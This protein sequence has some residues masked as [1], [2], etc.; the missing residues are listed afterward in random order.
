LGVESTLYAQPKLLYHL[1]DEIRPS[2]CEEKVGIVEYLLELVHN[3][4]TWGINV[5]CMAVIGNDLH[6]KHKLMLSFPILAEAINIFIVVIM[7]K[8]CVI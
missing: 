5:K 3:T 1:C 6:V 4:G 2:L 8:S 7:K